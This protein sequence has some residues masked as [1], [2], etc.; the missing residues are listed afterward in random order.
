MSEEKEKGPGRAFAGMPGM[1]KELDAA[2][3]AARAGSKVLVENFRKGLPAERKSPRELVTEADLKSE[4]RIIGI[5]QD[6]FPDYALWSEE[7]GDLRQEHD[8]RWIVDPLDGTHNF[9]FGLPIFGIAIALAVKGRI[10]CSAISLPAF[11]E[12]YT[13]ERGKGAFLNGRRIHVSKRP[14]ENAAAILCEHFFD[15]PEG[16][17]KFKEL[18]SKLFSI[19][20]FGASVFSHGALASGYIDAIVEFREKIGDFAAGW[21]LVEEAGGKFTTISGDEFSLDNSSYIASSGVF[22]KQLVEIMEGLG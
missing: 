21:L 9:F 11:N 4:S 20:R 3:R 12:L 14:M 19:R 18:E 15:S 22:H 5:L 6:S 1:S 8:H 17:K 10:K 7:A 13:A 2:V 16:F